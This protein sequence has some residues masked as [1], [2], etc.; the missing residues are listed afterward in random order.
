MLLRQEN[1]ARTSA[2]SGFFSAICF[3]ALIFAVNIAAQTNG[4]P[5]A[6]TLLPTISATREIIGGQAHA[7]KISSSANQFVFVAVEQ[8]GA[9]VSLALFDFDNKKLLEINSPNGASG[10]ELLAFIAPR[11]GDYSLEIAAPNKS[12]PAGRYEAKIIE[13]RGAKAEDERQIAAFEST[14]EANKLFAASNPENLPQVFELYQKALNDWQASGNRIGEAATLQYLGAAYVAAG[15]RRKALGFFA[16]SLALWQKL[17]ITSETANSHNL[18]C[19][20]NYRLSRFQEA[21]NHAEAALRIYRGNGDKIG[22]SAILMLLGNL[23]AELG[24]TASA[25][26]YYNQ[27]AQNWRSIGNLHRVAATL[28]NIGLT[29]RDA[30]DAQ[31]AFEF[32]NQSLQTFRADRP[33]T[34][35]EANVLNQLG[36]YFLEKGDL[37][38]A[39]AHFNQG[40]PIWKRI[41][42]AFGEPVTLLGIG[43]VYEKM[44][45]AQQAVEN[46]NQSLAVAQKRGSRGVEASVLFA[47]A[48]IERRREN[49][50]AAKEKIESALEIIEATRAGILSEQFRAGYFARTQKFYDF[51]ISLLMQMHQSA[52]AVGFNALALQAAERARARSLAE[53]LAE[54]NADIRHGVE[55]A[56]LER[57]KD[58][59]QKINAA[60]Q[61]RFQLILQKRPASQV[62]A[63]E[64]ALRRNLDEYKSIQADIR[65]RSPRYAALTQPQILSLR[66]IQTQILDADTVLLE[67]ALGEEKSFLF[68][69]SQKSIKSFVLPGRAEIEGAARN[70]Y[71]KIKTESFVA[72]AE[73]SAKNL[74]RIILE[75]A[76]AELRSKRLL[77]A[78]DGALQYIPFA[79]LKV[80]GSDE[81]NEQ[82]LIETNEIVMLPSATTLAILRRETA[83]RKPPT[84]TIAVIADPVFGLDD[85]RIK[86]T[87]SKPKETNDKLTLWQKTVLQATE[88][89]RSALPRLP[90]SRREAIAILALTTPAESKRALDFEA[91]RANILSADLSQYRYIHFA[92]HGL[93]DSRQ[94]ELTGIVLSLVDASGKPQDGFLRLHEIYNLKLPAELIVLSACETALGK[95]IKGEGI[96]GLTRGFMYAGAKRVAVSLWKVDDRATS[97]LMRR[98]YQEL[99][100]ER[101]PSPASALRA[102]QISMLREKRWQSPFYWS[103]FT[104]QGEWK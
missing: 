3:A 5:D 103:A 83:N 66:E 96:V 30:G 89:V 65:S 8:K 88:N 100:S 101:S 70:F 32:Y 104:L 69:V 59:Q 86:S 46:F 28:N 62:E 2:R 78:A 33:G 41:T 61:A 23:Y 11:G 85:L 6:Q 48:R 72:E 76:E 36:F 75:P 73:Q 50:T 42:D 81:N 9:D 22:E 29:Y 25:L 95:E 90:G 77:V 18:I 20:T 79:A 15:E 10:L 91:N 37:Q 54:A 99:L 21:L 56:L 16:E 40:L 47:Q 19:E 45:D 24:E 71:E 92:T 14:V 35:G 17:K 58:L 68:V 93:L 94:P 43:Q 34:R 12:A 67:Y 64:I 4:S 53:L 74:S 98:F 39:L 51:Y 57:E 97:E 13:M 44:G 60:E 27:A 84:K 52:P 7:Y 80:Q 102:A 63:A 82:F 38:N 31:K 26:D 55:P 87:A 1:S 49:L